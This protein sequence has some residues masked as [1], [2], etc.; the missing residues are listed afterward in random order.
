MGRIVT[1]AVGL[2]V[3]V[4]LIVFAFENA[5]PVTVSFLLWRTSEE[6]PLWGVAFLAFFAG[7]VTPLAV[8][9]AQ[10][11]G[12]RAADGGRRPARIAPLH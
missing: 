11:I 6:L 5:Q 7:A 1:F 3:G 12:R 8:L 10:A 9:V 4:A 2:V